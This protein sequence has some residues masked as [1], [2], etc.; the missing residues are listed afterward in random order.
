MTVSP[1]RRRR[2]CSIAA[3]AIAVC[4]ATL[5]A[6]D[7]L[8]ARLFSG[9]IPQPPVNSIGWIESVVDLEVN[10]RGAIV[11]ATALRGTPGAFEF[12]EPFLRNWTFRAATDGNDSVA[13]HVLVGM[14]MRPP[15]LLDPAAGQPSADLAPASDAVPYPTSMAR[16]VYPANTIGDR[17]V[18]VELVV[19]ADGTVERAGIVGSPSSFDSAA[20]TAARA[21]TFRAPR[22]KGQPVPGAAYLILGFRAP[23]V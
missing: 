18:L 22:Y 1:I 4:C 21:W 20:L 6:A 2:N 3:L 23:V 5:H 10:A 16:P 13:S 7:Y 9:G 17:A 8:P 12:I 19:A 14:L 11:K 15:Q